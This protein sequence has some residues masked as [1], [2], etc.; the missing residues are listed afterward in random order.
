MSV[1]RC[2]LA[3]IFCLTRHVLTFSANDQTAFYVK[4]VERRMRSPGKVRLSRNK[5]SSNSSGPKSVTCTCPTVEAAICKCVHEGVT[6]EI[7]APFASLLLEEQVSRPVQWPPLTQYQINKDLNNLTGIEEP[8]NYLKR[9]P[10]SLSKIATTFTVSYMELNKKLSTFKMDYT[11]LKSWNSK[12]KNKPSKLYVLVHGWTGSPADL[13]YQSLKSGLLHRLS[14]FPIALIDVNWNRRNPTLYSQAVADT[15]VIGRQ[16]AYLIFVL[17]R[18]GK[19]DPENV[20]LLGIDM[21]SHIASIA[22]VTFSTLA[23][24]YNTVSPKSRIGTR[25]GRRTGFNPLA[26]HFYRVLEDNYLTDAKFVDI[27]HTTI[28][29]S[30]A[31]GG[32]DDDILKRKIGISTLGDDYSYNLNRLHFYPNGGSPGSECEDRRFGCELNLATGY[33]AASLR[34]YYNRSAFTSYQCDSYK[35]LNRCSR[36]TDTATSTGVMGIDADSTSSRGNHFLRFSIPKEAL[37]KDDFEPSFTCQVRGGPHLP[38]VTPQVRYQSQFG[39]WPGCGKFKPQTSRKKRNSGEERLFKGTVPVKGHLPSTVCIIGMDIWYRDIDFD[40][41][42]GKLDVTRNKLRNED[43]YKDP[44]PLVYDQK[45]TNRFYAP[46]GWTTK[47]TG[48]LISDR[49]VVTAAH[50]FK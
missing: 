5:Y 19:C 16:L 6:Y 26:R 24:N 43:D 32:S 47:C 2:R 14:E 41:T 34:T 37:L 50:C 49:W 23:E 28:A 31:R 9:M 27:Y 30:A 35:N 44:L 40:K 46:W 22:A 29:S 39:D 12:I 36:Y 1:V 20:H 7:E 38:I 3:I 18:G 17:V 8:L 21:G 15:A 11:T 42:T 4:N 48:S 13:E 25:L 10:R 45:T 33:F